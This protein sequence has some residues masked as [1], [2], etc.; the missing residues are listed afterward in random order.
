[1]TMVQ[2]LGEWIV[3]SSI[4]IL[5][6]AL[7]LWLLRVKNPSIRLTA[8]TAILVGS[9]AIPLLTAALPKAPLPVLRRPSRPSPAARSALAGGPVVI[10]PRIDVPDLTSAAAPA[11]AV[12]AKPF[13]WVRVAAIPYT[14][15]AGAL[16]LRLFGGLA[17]SLRILG[18]SRP[19]GIVGQ[20]IEVRESDRVAS[21]V[22]VGILRPVALL[23]LD[24]R[25]WDPAKLNAVLAHERSHI[26]RRDPAVQFVSAIHRALLWASPLSWVLD[27]SI[28]RA[29]E[30]VSDFDAIA[31]TRDRLSYAEILL[32]FVQRG[33]GQTYAPGVSMARYDRPEKR[34]HGILSAT[35]IPRPATRW[36]IAATLALAAPL[37]YLAAATYP[38]SAPR[39]DPPAVQ[40]A[41]APAPRPAD[42]VP[43]GAPTPTEASA[44]IPVPEA[45]PQSGTAQ[46]KPAAELPAFEVASI[47]PIE[48]GVG[49]WMGVQVH[50]GGRV[51]ISA[52]PLKTLITTA[53]GVSYWQIS[54]GNK[55]TG[56]DR[57]YLEAKPSEAMQPSIKDLRHT[58]FGIEDEHL[59]EMLQ[60]LLIDRFQLKFHRETKAGDVYLLARSGASLR[61]RPIEIPATGADSS[62]DHRL[63]GSI[64]YAGGQWNIS[65][66]SM[67]QL[68][69][70]AS[71]FVLHVPVSD[72]TEISGWF[73]YR[74]RE[75][76][77]E[78][79][80]SGDQSDSFLS[81]L[82]E[83][84]LKL[85]RAK[86]PVVT[87]VIDHAEK[88]S[89]N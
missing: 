89:P 67:P 43:A 57:Y 80:Y 14:L 22:A 7:L 16:L 30:Q 46:D 49:G 63:Q 34:I 56:E 71:D 85:T 12:N 37:A 26:R 73:Y 42:A 19:T 60:A 23:P 4:L 61:L 62:A 66:T 17:L 2:F 24:W 25:D 75:P 45:V 9:M 84:G 38:Q 52:L 77:L 83:I 79:V 1:M 13:D 59:R 78:P 48:P 11:R 5:V 87:F 72:R 39:P 82:R 31:A 64:G 10:L 51:V 18:R 65:A 58:L 41:L 35:A 33:A 76:D 3:R 20:G 36:G 86:G 40:L 88:P 6:G 32:E 68:A 70:F 27:R 54:G 44:P 81:Y 15:A 21:P 29:A 47:K 55:W 74:Q 50:A 8:W 53:F 28:V 69:K